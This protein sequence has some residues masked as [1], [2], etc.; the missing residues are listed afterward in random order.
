MTKAVITH[1]HLATFLSMVP[2]HVLGH[3]TYDS[4]GPKHW[5]LQKYLFQFLTHQISLP[6]IVNVRPLYGSAKLPH[7]YHDGRKLLSGDFGVLAGVFDKDGVLCDPHAGRD[8]WRHNL[9]DRGD[10]A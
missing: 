5:I 4:V 8:E 10:F 6:L 3:G 2:S 1:P 9:Q 7:A